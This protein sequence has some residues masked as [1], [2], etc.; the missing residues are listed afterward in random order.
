MKLKFSATDCD[1]PWDRGRSHS[2]PCRKPLISRVKPIPG[3]TTARRG[4]PRPEFRVQRCVS[5]PGMEL[6]GGGQFGAGRGHT[7]WRRRIMRSGCGG[8][9]SSWGSPAARTGPQ[10][11][12]SPHADATGVSLQPPV[13]IDPH[14]T[15]A[16]PPLSSARPAL[17]LD[18]F[19]SSEAAIAG[20]IASFKCM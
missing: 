3:S 14:L 7:P 20:A 12:E 2:P 5:E 10:S 9:R 15:R 8:H 1:G 18:I 16:A 19:Q 4:C 13:C 17:N 11:W 6:G